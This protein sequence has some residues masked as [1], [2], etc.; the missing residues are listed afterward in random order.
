VKLAIFHYHFLTGGVSTVVTQA[1]RAIREHLPEVEEIRLVGGRCMEGLPAELQRQRAA[2]CHF[3]QIDYREAPEGGAPQAAAEGRELASLLLERYGGS[4]VVWWV[5]NYH[6]G[7]NPVFTQGLLEAL[8]R[9][10]AQRAILQIHDFPECGRHAN[11][12][13]LR[14]L[15]SLDPYPILPNVRYA[16]LNP[17]DHAVLLAAGVPEDAVHLL[18]NPVPA[19]PPNGAW[20][21]P[22]SGPELRARLASAFGGE[23]P[24]YD[25]ARPLAVYP[26]R[27]IRRKNVLE[28]CLL[29]R[30]PEGELSLAVTLPGISRAEKAYSDRVA[31]AFRAGVCRGLWGIG[32]RLQEA[33][34][35]FEELIAGADLVVSSAVQEGYGY[36]FVNS[37]QWRKP[38]L[39]RDLD[40]LEGVRG[41]FEDYPARLYRSAACPLEDRLR[42]ELRDAYGRKLRELSDTIPKEAR[43]QIEAELEGML[44]AGEVDFSYLPVQEQAALLRRLSD[45]GLVEELRQANRELVEAIPRLLASPVPDR[46]EEVEK[47]CG[48]PRFAADFG[49]LLRSLATPGGPRAAAAADTPAAGNVQE[50]LIRRF[51]RLEHLRLLYD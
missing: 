49:A 15:V 38:L 48:L 30:L 45:G 6:L 25:P 39:A 19:A 23:F 37:L 47:R 5:H 11:L 24:G 21:S 35:S 14:R 40:A 18:G 9:Q 51:A 46:R 12:R 4:D 36:L 2:Y 43:R 26:V 44:G 32:G 7:K 31:G 33:G 20:G 41:L 13:A 34:L 3:P 10:R 27:S 50:R 29:A 1:L 8:S 17:R 42:R 22:R 28:A 16:V